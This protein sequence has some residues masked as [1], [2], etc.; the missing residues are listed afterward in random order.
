MEPIRRF[1]GEYHFLSNFYNSPIKFNGILYANN[2]SAFQAQ[3]VLDNNIR[4]EFA[5]LPPNEGKR[6]GRRVRL[7]EDWETIKDYIMIQV[8]YAKFTQNKEL[9]EKL[10][11]TGSAYLE[12]GNTWNDTYWGVCRGYGANKLGYTLMAV[13]EMIREQEKESETV[14]VVVQVDKLTGHSIVW[15]VYDSEEKAQ[16]FCNEY[17]REGYRYRWEDWLVR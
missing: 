4:L 11:A 13:R 5:N 16:D 7:R 2:E 12:E 15:K 10:L 1:A 8:V 17:N 3:K 9:K 14:Y 6:K